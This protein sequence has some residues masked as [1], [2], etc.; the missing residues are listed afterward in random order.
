ME[1]YEIVQLVNSLKI[2][3]EED[4]DVIL[5]DGDISDVGR[6]KLIA[7]LVYKVFSTKVIPRDLFRTQALRILKL[8]G[9]VT[10]ELIGNN[11]FILEFSSQMDQNRVLNNGPWNLFKNLIMFAE[12]DE[13]TKI[14]ELS[15]T[16][17]EVWIQ[18]H[19]IPLACMNQSC[20]E[21]IGNL[22][23][24]FTEVATRLKRECWG[25]FMRIQVSIDISKPLERLLCLSLGTGLELETLLLMYERI[26]TFCH[27]C[28]ILGHLVRDCL[29]SPFLGDN[30]KEILKFGALILASTRVGR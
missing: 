13:T 4:K 8:I 18:V 10:V 24:T 25:R 30:G 23:G 12:V 26:P 7:S 27:Q 17:L 16:M 28:G 21:R 15:F 3:T 2:S 22:I 9:S 20:A 19:N 6:R 14:T 11:L 5:L 1:Q 29:E